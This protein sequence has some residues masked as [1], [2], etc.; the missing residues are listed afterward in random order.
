M[1][2]DEHNDSGSIIA[3]LSL[4]AAVELCEPLGFALSEESAKAANEFMKS[5]I[6]ESGFQT[7]TKKLWAFFKKHAAETLPPQAADRTVD[8]FHR[9]FTGY[10]PSNP[11]MSWANVINKYANS[12]DGW[13]D[14][15]QTELEQ[16]QIDAFSKFF[17][18]KWDRNAFNEQLWKIEDQFDLTPWD[19]EVHMKYGYVYGDADAGN[20]PFLSLKYVKLGH[21]LRT[22][23]K[24]FDFAGKPDF[25][26]L[27]MRHAGQIYLGSSWMPPNTPLGTLLEVV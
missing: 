10:H 14:V 15:G 7:N 13:P 1:I 24:E 2:Y 9:A 20:D 8:W 5:V 12:P 6:N 4:D 17:L 3:P 25:P 16:T 23:I 18:E 27:K 19:R 11:N 22:A 26:H 21:A